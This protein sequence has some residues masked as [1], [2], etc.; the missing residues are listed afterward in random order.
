MIYNNA[1]MGNGGLTGYKTKN[2]SFNPAEVLEKQRRSANKW[3][4]EEMQGDGEPESFAAKLKRAGDNA[5]SKT[6][7]SGRF[8]CHCAETDG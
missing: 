3:K 5:A 2:T 8:D 4:M 7:H 1:Y 6:Y